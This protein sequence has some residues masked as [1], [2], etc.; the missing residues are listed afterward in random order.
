MVIADL[1][2]F[3]IYVPNG[4]LFYAEAF[5]EKNISDRSVEYFLEN[6]SNDWQS[7]D[8]HS[9]DKD[10]LSKV[11][12]K[13]INWQH[14]KINMYGKEMYLPRY[15]AWYGDTDKSY[16][17]SG[18]HLEPNV[19]NKGLLYLKERIESITD[20]KFNSVLMNWY[21]DGFDHIGWHTDAESELGQNPVIA[22]LNFGA[23]RDFVIRTKDK[24][25]KMSIPLKHGTLLI[26]GGALQHFWE[27][28]V[29][30]RKKVKEA[31]FNLTF[32]VIKHDHA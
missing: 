30:P 5:I 18:I 20:V 14:D 12:F 7:V 6:D 17:Y 8:W 26:M 31:R 27:H 32:R 24:S 25:Q 15:S 13:N 29:P 10:A 2:G 1:K 23:S 3:E 16:T 22:S 19:W 21:R 4:Y 11:K 28:S 9:L